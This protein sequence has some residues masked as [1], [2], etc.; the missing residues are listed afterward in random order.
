MFVAIHRPSASRCSASPR[1]KGE[2]EYSTR[3]GTSLHTTEVGGTRPGTL[4]VT[5]APMLELGYCTSGRLFEAAACGAPVVS[6]AWEGLDT[7][8]T[9][10]DEILVARAAERLGG[11]Q[12]ADRFQEVGLALRIRANEDIQGGRKRCR[13]CRIISIMP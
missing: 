7:F 9:P 12:K 1:P 11:S 6:D 3:G 8:F 2:S 10:G 5:R 4:N 13:K